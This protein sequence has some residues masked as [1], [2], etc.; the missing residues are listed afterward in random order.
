MLAYN[1][2]Q[3]KEVGGF[4]PWWFCGEEYFFYNKSF[5]G[6]QCRQFLL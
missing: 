4:L 5:C 2:W 1:G 6:A 3:L